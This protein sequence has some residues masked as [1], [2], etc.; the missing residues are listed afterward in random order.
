[1]ETDLC[2]RSQNGKT[3]QDVFPGCKAAEGGHKIN[4]K[5]PG[6]NI[7]HRDSSGATLMSHARRKEAAHLLGAAIQGI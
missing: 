2:R 7:N 4:V 5:G 1:M 3:F 6:K